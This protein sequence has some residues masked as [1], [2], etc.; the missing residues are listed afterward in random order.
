[1]IATIPNDHFAYFQSVPTA[2][3]ICVTDLRYGL[4]DGQIIFI[5]EDPDSCQ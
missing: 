2:K 1:M 4:R 5:D 3:P